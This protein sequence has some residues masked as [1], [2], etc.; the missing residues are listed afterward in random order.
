MAEIITTKRDTEINRLLE[1]VIR[2]HRKDISAYSKGHLNEN[3]L[4]QPPESRRSAWPT[5]KLPA[6]RFK[7]PIKISDNKRKETMW[8]AVACFSAGSAFKCGL[9]SK[10]GED[11]Q[12][13]EPE[14]KKRD[15]INLEEF[16]ASYMILPRGDGHTYQIL[17]SIHGCLTKKEEVE[18]RRAFESKIIEKQN[19]TER[20]WLDGSRVKEGLVKS[21]S[22]HHSSKQAYDSMFEELCGRCVIYQPLLTDIRTFYNKYLYKLNEQRSETVDKPTG[23]KKTPEVVKLSK[24]IRKVQKQVDQL[25][26]RAMEQLNKKNGLTEE[27]EITTAV[28]SELQLTYTAT[29]CTTQSVTSLDD[30]YTTNNIGSQI[31]GLRREILQSQ[32]ELDAVK[33]TQRREMVPAEVYHCMIQCVQ[34]SE[35]EIQKQIKTIE[36]LEQKEEVMQEQLDAL[37]GTM[38]LT[39]EQ[40][41]QLRELKI[42]LV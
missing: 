7:G 22:S 24:E 15:N 17:P 35:L 26:C 10:P 39:D 41:A 1:R 14:G 28:L 5:S 31:E 4:W 40:C 12:I 3:N 21:Y 29:S 20:G 11:E 13:G 9:P 37:F 19:L 23:S 38:N 2:D 36:V 25:E 42:S 27:L 30:T 34:G 32:S 16:D 18:Q 33:S 6:I 8:E